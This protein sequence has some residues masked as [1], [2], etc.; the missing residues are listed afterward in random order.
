[1]Q[2]ARSGESFDET[3]GLPQSQLRKRNGRTWFEHACNY[4]E[5]KWPAAA[6]KSRRSLAEALATVTPSLVSTTRD[7]PAPDVLR[8][9]LY[10]WAF[11]PGARGKPMPLEIASALR[12][13]ERGR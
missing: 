2:A 5:M 8:R 11:N 13:V 4:A 3:I 7:A 10:M 6:A 1:M 9:A 12:W